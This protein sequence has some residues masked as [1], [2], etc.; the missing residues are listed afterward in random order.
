MRFGRLAFALVLAA[1]QPVLAQTVPDQP[2]QPTQ[3][4]VQDQMQ[5]FQAYVTNDGYKKMLAQ[6]AIMGE[7]VSSPECKTHKPQERASLTVYNPPMFEAAL[8]PVAGLWVDRIKMDRCGTTSFQNIILQAQ[9]DGTPPRA[10]L[11]MPGTT[12]ANPPM[13][14]L[15]M[16]DFLAALGKKKCTDQSQI[17]PV[18]TKMEKETK[19]LKLD[20]KGM[21]SE[22]AWKETWTFKACGKTVNAAI[23]LAAD[24]KGGLT[25]KLKL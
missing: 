19:P 24:G 2:A 9:K 17:I 6:L 21:I 16:K 18:F 11:L 3:A 4:P 14:D 5:R 25:H 8:H 22:G 10:A 13:Q 7:T 12:M 15:I 20:G 1:T 23:D